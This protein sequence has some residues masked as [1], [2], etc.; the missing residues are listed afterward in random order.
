M[1]QAIGGPVAEDLAAV[2]APGAPGGGAAR[3]CA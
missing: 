2:L 3:T 1:A